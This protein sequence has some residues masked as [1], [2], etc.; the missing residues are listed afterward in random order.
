MKRFI[1]NIFFLAAFAVTVKGQDHFATVEPELE[2]L[3]F[4]SSA[5]TIDAEKLNIND[6]IKLIIDKY[7]RSDSVFHHT[8]ETLRYLG[9]ITAPDSSLKIITWNLNLSGGKG[10]YF[11][12]FIKKNE[13]KNKIYSLTAP[14]NDAEIKT[15]TIYSA[16]DWYGALYYETRRYNDEGK[17]YW[18]LL[19]LDY[20]NP[21]ISRKMIEP[22]SFA[23]NDSITFGKKCF[24]KEG[25]KTF[26]EVLGYASAATITLRFVSDSS[27]VFDHL[28][29][30][31]AE[32]KDKRQYYGPDYSYDAFILEKGVW[33]FSLNIDVRNRQ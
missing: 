11:C 32:L 2:K 26:R 19:G 1:L 7:V 17:D 30:F 22:L 14:Y 23:D 13:V 20:G 3:F 15:D 18:I 28:V 16:H 6:S 5:D 33:K 29:P 27:I 8:F 12:Y 24:E 21:V 25:R 4:R 9:Q 10:R 31:S